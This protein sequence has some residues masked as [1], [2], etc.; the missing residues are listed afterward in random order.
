MKSYSL[1]DINQRI[2]LEIYKPNRIDKVGNITTLDEPKQKE[3]LLGLNEITFSVPFTISKNFETIK[4]PLIDKLRSLYYI[5]ATTDIGDEEWYVI[6]KKNMQ[7]NDDG[8]EMLTV[9]LMSSGHE[10]INDKII[11]WLGVM[12]DGEY[13]KESLN[14]YQVLNE[15]LSDN[16]WSIDYIDAKYLT[17]Y[18]QFDFNNTTVLDAVVQVADTFGGVLVWDTV[19]EKLS[20]KDPETIGKNKGLRI[21]V[22]KYLKSL[23]YEEDA[24]SIVTMLIPRGA[25]GLTIHS[26]NPLGTGFIEDYSYF[27][28]GF[29]RDSNK[30]TISS[31]NYMSDDLCHG[32]LDHQETLEIHKDSYKTFLSQREAF[33]KQLVPLNKQIFDL[34]TKRKQLE[35]SIE[36]EKLN[37]RDYSQLQIELNNT[38]NEITNVYSQIDVLDKQID[39]IVQSMSDLSE[40]LAL[41]SFLS[42]T[43]LEELK[44]YQRKQDWEDTNYVDAQD[45]YDDGLKALKELSQPKFVINCDI[46]DIYSIVGMDK[47][48]HKLKLGD[49]FIIE[50]PN[51]DIEHEAQL[52]E[53]EVDYHGHS[54]SIVI[55]NV[56][57]VSS[58]DKVADVIKHAI[59]TG[60]TVDLN[61]SNWDNIS[62]LDSEVRQFMQGKLDAA[63]NSIEAGVNNTVLINERG[64]TTTSTDDP[65]RFIRINN[66][67]IALTNDGANTYKTAITAEGV[68]AEQLIGNIL[69]GESLYLENEGKFRFDNQGVTID[70][71]AFN[72]IG[73][74]PK[75][76]LEPSFADGLFELNKDYTNGIRMDSVTGINVT[77]SDGNASLL[78]NATDGIKFKSKIGTQWRDDFYFDPNEKRYVFNGEL[79]ALALK[80]AG[81]SVLT[82]DDKIKADALEDLVVGGN[83]TMGANASISWGQVGDKPFIP[84]NASDIGAVSSSD[85]RLTYIG[86]D[87]IITGRF[88]A[89]NIL[90]GTISGVTINVNTDLKVGN[91]IL[92]GNPQDLYNA[93]GILFSNALNDEAEIYYYQ[94]YMSLRS[95]SMELNTRTLMLDC[96]TLDLSTINTVYWGNNA[97]TAKFA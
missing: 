92:I 51:F 48:K 50:H 41:S 39:S 70:G 23:S 21:K 69:I 58:A 35:D 12:I 32:L 85:R 79:N 30:T 61:K 52:T 68:I 64:I 81:K 22:G 37:N 90:G 74:L 24:D 54:I 5:K 59:Q 57:K 75:S 14:A 25:D 26:V 28:R 47:A 96:Y 3:L 33:E 10:L 1:S 97:P 80:V 72:I 9:T 4:N 19:N 53:F 71:T 46:V 65:N 93:K 17:K 27:M 94:G 42:P 55:S 56:K 89:D 83:V 60:K 18:R 38:N 45:L 82:T 2:K 95:A 87:G 11:T 77:R 15:L 31:S 36:I 40:Q 16:K 6:T 34:T 76:Q 67:L 91:N 7:L 73:G 43:L 8:Q 88:Y 44:R 78:M 63:K 20:L 29:E 86:Q 84:Q 62:N 13:Q 49:K 66:G